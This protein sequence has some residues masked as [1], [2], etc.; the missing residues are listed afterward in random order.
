MMASSAAAGAA[1]L[2]GRFSQSIGAACDTDPVRHTPG[3]GLAAL[4]LIVGGIGAI[5][6]APE[7]M[8]VVHSSDRL[9]Y[10]G[11]LVAGRVL[12]LCPCASALTDNK[13]NKGLY[14]ARTGLQV[15][16]LTT[17]APQTA[18]ARLRELPTLTAGAWRW[19]SRGRR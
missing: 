10:A 1:A 13:Y 4:A 15:A 2:S 3:R 6:A 18:V 9:H 17:A 11:H 7:L 8:Q 16:L 19:M 12:S 5:A 14:H